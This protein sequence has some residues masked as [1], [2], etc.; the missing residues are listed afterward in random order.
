MDGAI[1]HVVA[2][3][4]VLAADVLDDADVASADDGLDGVVVAVERRAEMRALR[5]WR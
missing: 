4:A 3:G 5:G 1:H 2:L